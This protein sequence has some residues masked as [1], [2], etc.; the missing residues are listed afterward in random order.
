MGVCEEAFAMTA[1]TS[2]NAGSSSGTTPNMFLDPA[3]TPAM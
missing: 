1:G 2:P 3:D